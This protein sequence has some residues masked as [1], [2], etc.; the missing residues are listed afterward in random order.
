M[1]W[2]SLVRGMLADENS[3]LHDELLRE[4]R[5]RLRSCWSTASSTR[6]MHVT[7]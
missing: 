2:E 7:S 6:T 1:S 4:K 3:D 5:S